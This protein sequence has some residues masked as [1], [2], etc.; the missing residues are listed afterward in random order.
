MGAVRINQMGYSLNCAKQVVYVGKGDAFFIFQA[1]SKKQVFEGILVDHGYDEASGE[2]ICTGDFS[3]L[4]KPGQYFIVINNEQSLEFIISEDRYRICA[5]ALLKSFYYQRCGIQLKEEY[6][7]KWKHSDCHLQP[8]YLFRQDA[9]QLLANEPE[10]MIQIDTSGGWHDAG[11]YG[12]YTIATVKVVADLMSAY[13]NYPDFFNHT[14]GIPESILEGA[15]ILYEVR[16]GLD[17]LFKMQRLEDGAVYTKVA[18]RYFPGMI[19][20]EEDTLPLFVYDISSPA[21]AGFTA[22][23]AMAYE[24]YQEIDLTYASKCLEVS[25]RAYEWLKKN[26][27]PLLFTNPANISSG[28]YG[29][30]SDIDERYWAAARLYHATGMECYH[31]DF[32]MYY[33]MLKDTCSF[34]WRDVGGYGTVAYLFTHQPVNQE[35]F[36]ELKG[37]WLRFADSLVDRSS[38]NG[39]G[40]TLGN[41]DYVWGSNMLLM[42]QSI[43]LILAQK[44]FKTSVYSTVIQHN[45][46][47]LFGNNPMDISYVT[48]MG[49][50]SASNPHHR[51][52]ASDHISEPVPGLVCGGPCASLLDD[53]VREHCQGLPIAKCF[54]DQSDSYSTNETDIYWDSP[55]VYVGAYL[56]D[57][58]S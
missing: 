45:W 26:Q 41:K 47:Y 9:E 32:I 55:A 27:E 43:H 22:V 31:N 34:G 46:D 20:P 36:N 18:T 17:F 8:S 53:I 28:E 2:T 51:P 57:I 25:I 11:D 37:Q 35:I 15:D 30:S 48:G 40:I 58:Q 14:I 6:A 21:T 29:D 49:E 42:N 16:V 10:K 39:Y 5:D 54:V 33:L 44:L 23:M 12:R 24:V 50:R 3:S 1:E 19:M 56:C 4:E 52:S 38:K 13:L 7:G